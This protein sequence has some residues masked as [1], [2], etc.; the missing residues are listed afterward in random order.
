MFTLQEIEYVP[1][2]VRHMQESYFLHSKK[3]RETDLDL[4]IKVTHH[5][6]L[7]NSLQK[8][9]EIISNPS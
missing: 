7:P 8:Q 5:S 9:K 2:L 4:P 6:M 3:H 1:G